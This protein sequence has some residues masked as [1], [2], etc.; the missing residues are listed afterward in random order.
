MKIFQ[1]TILI[2]FSVILFLGNSFGFDVFQHFC[3]EEGSLSIAYIINDIDHCE[4]NV[5]EKQSCCSTQEE[6]EEQK[7]DDCCNDEI[8]HIQIKLDY[9]EVFQTPDF[10]IIQID[11][12]F[13]TIENSFVIESEYNVSIS[14]YPNPPP[15]SGREIGIKNQVFII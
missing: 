12:P 5:T 6:Q 3:K 1:S 2:S 4:K 15:I 8:E 14:T 10:R 11:L 13:Y 7:D 9:S